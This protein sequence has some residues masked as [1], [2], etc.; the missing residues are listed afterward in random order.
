MLELSQDLYVQNQTEENERCGDPQVEKVHI[1][2]NHSG[3]IE[4]LVAELQLKSTK[5]ETPISLTT[6]A[7]VFPLP[8][9]VLSQYTNKYF[10][11]FNRQ[12]H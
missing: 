8:I 4:V 10:Y 5:S 3:E 1:A 11:L 12:D 6:A 9:D 2:V 7:V